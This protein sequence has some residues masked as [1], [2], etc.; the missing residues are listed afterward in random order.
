MVDYAI[1]GSGPLFIRDI[2]P[3]SNDLDIVCRGAAWEQ[4]RKIGALECLPDFDVTI[5]NLD[6]GQISFG[7]Q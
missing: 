6:G 4:V 3:V 2:I 7:T 1:F 5:V